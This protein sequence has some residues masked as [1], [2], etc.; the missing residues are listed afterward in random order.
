MKK[1]R[2][3]IDIDSIQLNT[4]QIGWL[5]HNPRKWTQDD[6]DRTAASVAEDGDFL[7]DRPILV[8][9][10]GEGFVAFGGNLR[11]EGCAASG[12]SAAPCVVYYP[13]TDE[14]FATIKRRAMKDNGS[15]GA[16]DTDIL[17]NEWDDLPLSEW[18][19]P[20]WLTPADNIDLD[21]L[22]DEDKQA[23]KSTISI[24]VQI[25]KDMADQEEDIRAAI[26]VTV[27]EF[28]GVKVK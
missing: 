10:F 23:V 28:P 11:R 27:E 12:R 5:P 15:F 25:P 22:F 13:E 21:G 9:P 20:D 18:G 19:L 24:T 1:E 7:E 14:D 3:T 26:K 17:A 4:G 16:W 6:I 2:K 8:V